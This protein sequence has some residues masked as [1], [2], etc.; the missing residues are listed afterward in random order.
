MTK[1]G[2]PASTALRRSFGSHRLSAR[3]RLVRRNV[4]T[5]RFART[6]FGAMPGIR[7]DGAKSRA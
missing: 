7:Q 6:S 5:V 1:G 4:P 2:A 3:S